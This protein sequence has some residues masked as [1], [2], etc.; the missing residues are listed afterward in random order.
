V[1]PEKDVAKG[2]GKGEIRETGSARVIRA[3]KHETHHK[4]E[5]NEMKKNLS[6]KHI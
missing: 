3:A 2:A 4:E 5:E 1:R 6:L